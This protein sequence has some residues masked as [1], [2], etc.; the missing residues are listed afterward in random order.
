MDSVFRFF[1][2]SLREIK[3]FFALA[4]PSPYRR[5]L[6]EGK[7]IN[8]Y[9]N[10]FRR[11]LRFR[12]L[13]F[14]V[15]MTPAAYQQFVAVVDTPAHRQLNEADRWHK[16]IAALID[17]HQNSEVTSAEFEV[18]VVDPDG[19][20][21]NKMIKVVVTDHAPGVDGMVFMLPEEDNPVSQ[22]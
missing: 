11:V 14:P 5:A 13:D 12:G 6:R 19:V 21:R 3:R 16:V 2:T 8:L 1:S 15:A 22:R 20:L 18:K 9:K 17:Y 10:P 4:K 7:L